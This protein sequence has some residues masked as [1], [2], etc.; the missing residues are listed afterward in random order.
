M[1]EVIIEFEIS[2]IPTLWNGDD[3][4]VFAVKPSDFLED[5]DQ[6]HTALYI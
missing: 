3:I 4:Y 6:K 5:Y 1:V 2:D